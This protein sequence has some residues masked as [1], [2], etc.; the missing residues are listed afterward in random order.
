MKDNRVMAVFIPYSDF[1][2]KLKLIIF[3]FVFIL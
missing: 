1:F 2:E 3:E